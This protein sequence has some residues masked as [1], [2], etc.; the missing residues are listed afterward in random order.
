MRTIARKSDE[1]ALSTAWSFCFA[2]EV[3]PSWKAWLRLRSRGVLQA[4]GRR[5]GCRPETKVRS[6]AC[7]EDSY[8]ARSALF[9][10]RFRCLRTVMFARWKIEG[11]RYAEVLLHSSNGSVPGMPKR[12][13]GKK[14][15]DG[16]S[17]YAGQ[18]TLNV[19]MQP[20]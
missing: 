20:I 5:A 16:K 7:R 11:D 17:S 4:A 12:N 14:H 9:L 10:S 15:L 6:P 8:R 1:F 3:L 19:C 2:S 13:F 18:T